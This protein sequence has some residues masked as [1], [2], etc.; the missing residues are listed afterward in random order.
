MTK[1]RSQVL[2]PWVNVSYNRLSGIQRPCFH[3]F[4]QVARN[5]CFALHA[6]L[7]KFPPVLAFLTISWNGA[8]ELLRQPLVLILVTVPSL[9]MVLMSHV[10]Y[11]ALESEDKLVKDSALAL[12]FL[13]GL[14]AAVFCASN[15]LALELRTGTALAVLAKPVSRAKFLMAKYFGVVIALTLVVYVNCLTAMLCSRMVPDIYQAHDPPAVTSAL[16]GIVLGLMLG[17]YTN[18]FLHRQFIGDAV[19]GIVGFSSITFIAVCFVGKRWDMHAFGTLMDWRMLPAGVL[20]LFALFVLA[21]IA[22]ACSTRLELMPTLAMC[23]IIFMLGLMTDYLFGRTAAD[24]AI[25]AKVLYT[26][27][28][29]WQ[30]FWMVDALEGNKSIPFSYV[31]RAF[32]YVVCYVVAA[33][34][35]G[36]AL[37]EDRELA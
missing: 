19:L 29:N 31:I 12:V 6:K 2:L 27:L 4:A 16:L 1:S 24:G 13:I 23:S 37:F 3:G 10:P 36:L 32:S 5:E 25:W 18:F 7:I 11:L 28:P 33:M 20:I 30:L 14:M 34:S 8:R 35:A 17:G 21:S 9:F 15:T 26:V 22:L